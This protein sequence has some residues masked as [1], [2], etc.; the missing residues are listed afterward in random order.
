MGDGGMLFGIASDRSAAEDKGRERERRRRWR[1]ACC[2]RERLSLSLLPSLP[3]SLSLISSEGRVGEQT[4]RHNQACRH[5]PGHGE[6]VGHDDLGV[7]LWRLEQAAEVDVLVAVLVAAFGVC[8]CV[9]FV[10]C[11][12]VR[13]CFRCVVVGWA[14]Q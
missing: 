2:G 7:M 1:H 8:V 13:V 4:H 12:S 14:G 9:C 6:A 10:M 3:L 11:V 5:A